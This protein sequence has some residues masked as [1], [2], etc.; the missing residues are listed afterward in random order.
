[1]SRL[2]LVLVVS[3]LA[4]CET[5]WKAG[6]GRASAS[7]VRAVL[8]GAAIPTEGL[9][10]EMVGATRDVECRMQAGPEAARRI[11]SGLRLTAIDASSPPSLAAF[12]R[13]RAPHEVASTKGSILAFVT[14]GRPEVL[15]L[16]RGTAFEY[17]V[18]YWDPGT[19]VVWF[20]L[21]YSYG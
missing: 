17:L 3:L 4:G 9:D 11:A 6:Q 8:A 13:Q 16:K 5:L 2:G 15:R 10:C 20:R 1:V 21:S 12:V 19:N 14:T 18:L 7:D